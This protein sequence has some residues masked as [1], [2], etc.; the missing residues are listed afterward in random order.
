MLWY[1]SIV[2]QT[3]SLVHFSNVEKL[4]LITTIHIL[5]RPYKKSERGH[6]LCGRVQKLT[7]L[8]W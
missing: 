7:N 8:I 3:N 1:P 6:N 4:P 5:T 2:L